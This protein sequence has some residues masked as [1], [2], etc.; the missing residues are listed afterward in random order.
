MLGA[1]ERASFTI[2]GALRW[3]SMVSWCFNVG[4]KIG[5]RA[6]NKQRGICNF[7]RENGLSRKI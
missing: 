1:S 7:I 4:S 6:N 5:K 3:Y 2:A